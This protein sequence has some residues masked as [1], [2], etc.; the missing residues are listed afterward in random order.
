MFD[1]VI[2]DSNFCPDHRLLLNEDIDDLEDVSTATHG[3]MTLK[4]ISKPLCDGV[5]IWINVNA[6]GGYQSKWQEAAKDFLT[7]KHP[8]ITRI[9]M[10]F[11][12][13]PDSELNRVVFANLK[14]EY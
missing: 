7:Q 11:A 1:E 8:D 5:K 3:K 2:K 10:Q 14:P 6:F 9:T 4:K 13:A 12:K